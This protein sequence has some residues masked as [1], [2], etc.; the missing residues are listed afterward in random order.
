GFV[1]DG[2]GRKMSKSVGNVVAPEE[3]IKKYGAEILRLWVA[4]Q[5]YRDDIRISQEILTRLSEAYRR[6]RNTCK[7]I[8]GNLS[9]FDPAVNAV[10]PAAMPEIDRWALHQLELLKEKVLSS[11]NDCEFHVLYHAV[12]GFCTVEMSAFYL[13]ILKDRVYTSRTDSVERRSAQTVMYRILDTLLRLVAP[14]LSFTADEAWHYLPGKHE[15]SVHLAA[16]PQLLPELKD[17]GLVE[18]WERIMKVRAEVQKA[19]EQARVAKTIGHSL[20]ARVVITADGELLA[21]LREYASE[22]AAIFI[23]SQVNLVGEISGD[24]YAAESVAGLRIAVD[25]APGGKCERC[26][27]YSEEL[28]TNGEHPAICPKCT[29]AVV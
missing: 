22:L 18:R 13:D 8:L 24:A 1:V 17:D 5:D 10:D 23:V 16:F 11:Y 6:I 15:E 4:A 9:D 26:W 27:C 2:S 3:V 25:A 29:A 21:F 12:N 19:L 14:V 28:G 7:Y 20:D